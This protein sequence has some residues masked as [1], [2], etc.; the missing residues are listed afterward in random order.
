MTAATVGDALTIAW[1]RRKPAAGLIHHSDRGSQYSSH[2]FQGKLA[3]LGMQWSIS[4]K[5]DCCDNAPTESFFN[6]LKK[7]P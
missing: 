2:A 6:N 4:R 3:A 1:F 7:A 5:G